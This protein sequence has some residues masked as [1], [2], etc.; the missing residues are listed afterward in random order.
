MAE[1]QTRTVPP[2]PPGEKLV[3]IVSYDREDGICSSCREKRLI[4][5]CYNAHLGTMNAWCK[6]CAAEVG[7]AT[8]GWELFVK[9]TWPRLRQVWEHNRRPEPDPKR[10]AVMRANRLKLSSAR[11]APRFHLLNG[12]NSG[13]PEG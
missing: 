1:R 13:T 12:G 2:K 3:V 5:Q 10:Q 11:P 9:T 6:E 8:D 7:E 4:F